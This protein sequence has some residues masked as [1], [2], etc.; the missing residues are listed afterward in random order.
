MQEYESNENNI[1]NIVWK[2]S[3]TRM[4]VLLHETGTGRFL[5]ENGRNNKLYSDLGKRVA[6]TGGFGAGWAEETGPGVPY[7]TSV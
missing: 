4:A 6:L 1:E 3:V 2:K 5:L 7:N